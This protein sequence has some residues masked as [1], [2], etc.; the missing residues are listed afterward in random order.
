MDEL[1]S[2]IDLQFLSQ[3]LKINI[4]AITFKDLYAYVPIGNGCYI[5]NLDDSY[6]GKYGTHW[7]AL[8]I[9][10]NTAA[11]FDPFGFPIP[12]SI[13]RFLKK[14]K[15]KKIYYSIDQIQTI[16]TSSCGYYVLYFLYF[17]SVLNK[18]NIHLKYLLNRHNSMYSIENKNLNNKILK[19]LIKNVFKK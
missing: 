12:T 4:K 9:F 14:N 2:N 15:V 7:T 6:S 11:Y 17:I 3:K 16:Q 10:S 19:E 5:I 18:N 13:K 8:Y 1:L